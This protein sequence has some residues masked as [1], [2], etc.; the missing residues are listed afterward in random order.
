[1]LSRGIADAGV[2]LRSANPGQPIEY[3]KVGKM[4][5]G[6]FTVMR[7]TQGHFGHLHCQ[8]ERAGHLR[9]VQWKP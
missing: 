1:M 6:G 4:T 7:E 2:A 5:A 3:V 9:P 8:P